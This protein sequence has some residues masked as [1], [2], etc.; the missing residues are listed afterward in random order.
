MAIKNTAPTNT[1]RGRYGRTSSGSSKG[2]RDMAP[3][4]AKNLPNHSNSPKTAINIEK[5]TTAKGN[6]R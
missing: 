1:S 6:P 5:A 4:G 3:A 2:I